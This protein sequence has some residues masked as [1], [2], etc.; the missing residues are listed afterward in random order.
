LPKV[1]YVTTPLQSTTATHGNNLMKISTRETTRWEGDIE[2]KGAQGLRREGKELKFHPFGSSQ[3]EERHERSKGRKR[4][5]VSLFFNDKGPR[6]RGG[7]TP[8]KP[9][10]KKKTA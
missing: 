1:S 2:G 3:H 10:V 6:T 7:K 9:R 8:T 5:G 4:R